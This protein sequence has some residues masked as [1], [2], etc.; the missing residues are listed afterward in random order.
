ML[1]RILRCALVAAG[2]LLLA[3]P[4]RAQGTSDGSLYSRF[5]LGVLQ[6]FGSS[7][8]EGMGGAGVALRSFNYVNFSNPAAWSDQVLTRAA[9][10][11][12]HQTTR[13]TDAQGNESRLAAG[14]LNGVQLSFPILNRR[15]GAAIGLAPYSRSNYR[16]QE[17]GFIRLDPGARDSARYVVDHEGRGG[18]QEFVAGLGYRL[19]SNLSVGANVSVLFGILEDARRTSFPARPDLDRTSLATSTR[20]AG[21]TARLGALYTTTSLLQRN[22]QLAVGAALTLPATLHGTRVRTLGESLDRDT[23]GT[24]QR[25]DTSIPLGASVGL[26]YW[27]NARW[28]LSAE[29]LY[30]GWSGFE[31]DF[32]LPGATDGGP[33]ALSDR[34]RAAAGVEFV[35]AGTD[36]LAP[37]LQRVAYRFGAYYDRSYVSPLADVDLQTLA[38]TGGLGL[39]TLLPGTHLDINLE[40]GTRGT[41][42]RGL[43]RDVFYRVTATVNIGERWFVK[44]KLR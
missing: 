30:Q 14:T 34:V 38:L 32:G 28:S 12:A 19:G 40:V 26:A 7:Q 6:S 5:G 31:S 41:T 25:G 1:P 13:I 9:I 24:R 3:A 11:M 33:G 18:L 16:V 4:A 23:L 37:F 42:D 2:L 20:M 15:L 22:D 39:P 8:V 35:P 36:L 17:E 43:V 27:P 29:G 21:V 10:G 44:Q